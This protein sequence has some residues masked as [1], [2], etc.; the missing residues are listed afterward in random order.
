MKSSRNGG[1][2]PSW[3]QKDGSSV[4]CVYRNVE[5]VL[6]RI[7]I[8]QSKEKEKIRETNKGVGVVVVISN[9]SH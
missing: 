3:S 1:M 2:L 8:V 4:I 6:P 9:D 5:I 7:R